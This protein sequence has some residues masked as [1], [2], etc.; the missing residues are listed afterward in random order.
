MNNV[1]LSHCFRSRTSSHSWLLIA[2]SRRSRNSSAL[3]SVKARNNCHHQYMCRYPTRTKYTSSSQHNNAIKPSPQ[4]SHRSSNKSKYFVI[5]LTTFF[6]I[7]AFG[8]YTH[9]HDNL[10]QYYPLP[11]AIDVGVGPSMLPTLTP[12]RGELYLRDV[13]SHRSIFSNDNREYKRGD[14][15]TMYNPYSQ[16]IVT[17]RIVGVEGDTIQ[18]F[19][20]YA[21]DFYKRDKDDGGVPVDSRFNP[22]FCQT[23]QQEYLEED[24]TYNNGTKNRVD[25]ND[26]TMKVPTKHVWVEGDNP[27]ESTDSRHYGPLPTSALRGRIV[28]RLWPMMSSGGFYRMTG[29]R[30]SPFSK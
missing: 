23:M 19:G 16:S 9:F 26:A 13:W 25:Y 20:E 30:P 10:F 7:N 27:L 24:I 6:A 2:T 12:D 4:Q 15:V 5:S 29:E 17:K 14:V 11:F 1:L 21:S 8:T 22:P 3:T 28:L 18:L